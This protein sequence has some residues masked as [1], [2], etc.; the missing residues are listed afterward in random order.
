MGAP[1]AISCATR[2]SHWNNFTSS[3]TSPAMNSK[4]R[5]ICWKGL[6]FPSSNLDRHWDQGRSRFDDG[7]TNPFQQIVR[8]FEFIAGDV[9]E[10]VKLFQCELRVAQEIAPGAPI[11][12]DA[13]QPDLFQTIDGFAHCAL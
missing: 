1:G 6:V 5:T 4:M 9:L 3:R 10:D 11:V 2:S 7:K 12:V 8:I 13:N